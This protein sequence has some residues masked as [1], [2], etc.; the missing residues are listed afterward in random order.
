LSA[1][2]SILDQKTYTTILD[3]LIEDSALTPEQIDQLKREFLITGRAFEDILVEKAW[4]SEEQLTRAKAEFNHVPFIAVADTGIS[5]EAMGLI[6]EN[7]AR[8]YGVLP[9]AIDKVDHTLS[10]AMKNPLDLQALN[11]IEQNGYKPLLILLVTAIDQLLPAIYKSLSAEVTMQLTILL[12]LK[13]GK[14]NKIL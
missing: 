4:L 12:K 2:K 1:A 13:P 3:V 6:E 14:V 5:P 9:F 8:R 7:V 10:V 11:F